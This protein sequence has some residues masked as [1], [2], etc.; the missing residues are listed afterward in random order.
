VKLDPESLQGKLL[1]S[2]RGG[3]C[4]EQNGLLCRVLRQL[5]YQVT[6]LF[7]R[8][9]KGRTDAGPPPRSHMLL[10]VEV[11]GESVIADVGFGSLTLTAPLRLYDGAVQ[12][13]P[14]GPFRILPENGEFVLQADW[15]GWN[16]IYRFSLEP[17]QLED[18]EA[19]NW[20]RSTHPESMFVRSLV[21]ARP[22]EGGRLGLL[23]NRYSVHRGGLAERRALRSGAEIADVLERDFG[24]ALPE[25]RAGLEARLDRLVV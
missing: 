22:V 18:Y 9:L 3:Y 19:A 11:A 5:G 21:A 4:Y 14:H 6:P 17:Q 8:V 16:A 23:N 20:Y 12:D 13:T 7:A 24:I 15:D 10:K 25:P 2:G 1:R